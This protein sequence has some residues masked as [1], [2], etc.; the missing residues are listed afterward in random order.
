MKASS[1]S[2]SGG[3]MAIRR[4]TSL[5]DSLDSRNDGVYDFRAWLQSFAVRIGFPTCRMWR[6]RSIEGFNGKLLEMHVTQQ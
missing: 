5:S 1:R 2:S 3:S 4:M 6:L